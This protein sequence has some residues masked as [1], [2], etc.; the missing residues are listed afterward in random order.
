MRPIPH[1][2]GASREGPARHAQK[3]AVP[4]G[5][6]VYLMAHDG[7]PPGALW[8]G[9]RLWPSAAFRL[10][11]SAGQPVCE[12]RDRFMDLMASRV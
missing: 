3:A 4:H 9:Y 1:S 10:P 12:S 7:S 5:P 11:L 8:Q 2:G 6:W